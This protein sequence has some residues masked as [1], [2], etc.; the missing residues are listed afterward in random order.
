MIWA[1]KFSLIMKELLI[2]PKLLIDE[3]LNFIKENKSKYIMHI[4]SGSDQEEL[5]YLCKH[6]RIEHLFS[7]INGSPTPKI[8]LIRKTI[9]KNAYNNEECIMIGDSINDWLA[10]VNN[11]IFFQAYNSPELNDKSTFILL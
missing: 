4:I 10:A 8:D 6:M 2:N 1:D 11:N 7:S 3:T 9:Q 5:R